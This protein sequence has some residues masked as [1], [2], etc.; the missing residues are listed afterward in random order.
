MSKRTEKEIAFYTEVLKLLVLLLVAT[1]GGTV[2]LL[3]KM[4]YSISIPLIF[5]GIWLS[6]SLVFG[7]AWTTLKIKRKLEELNE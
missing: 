2:S 3:Y 6:A 5:F 7:I 1:A 4:Q